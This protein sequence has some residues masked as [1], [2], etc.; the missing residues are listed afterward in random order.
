[1]TTTVFFLALLAQLYCVTIMVW[2]RG[3]TDMLRIG[4]LDDYQNA[5]LDSADWSSLN[6]VEITVFDTHL[7]FDEGAIIEALAPF[8]ILVAMRERTHFPRSLLEKLT[9]L[10]LLV[11]A[12]MRNQVIDLVAARDCKIEVCGT[13][14]VPYPA[15]EHTWALILAL[16]KQIP[17]EDRLM[18]AGGWQQGFGIGLQGKTLGILGL[19]RLGSKVAQVALAFDMK[20][21]AWSENLTNENAEACGAERVDKQALFARADILTIH[22]L[23]SSRTRGLVGAAELTLM[24]PDAYLINTARGPIVDEQA[25]ID[26]LSGGRIA[27]AA[28]DVFDVEPLP[29]DHPLR[30]MDNVVLTGHTGF[31]VREFHQLVYTQALEDI[32]S[33]MAGHSVRRLNE[34]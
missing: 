8:D 33:W 31:V 5:A 30:S 15:F 25:L 28:L 18:K 4:L 34:P 13:D 6:D 3:A 11:T 9:N 16:T 27:G 20:V 21:I 2:Q 12:G 22:Q 17:R 1:M 24:K 19:G 23:L 26:V 7:G 10:R 29:V 32:Q 14:L